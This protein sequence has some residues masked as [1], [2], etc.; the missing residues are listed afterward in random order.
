MK[1][2][3]PS[4][5]GA[6]ISAHFGRSRLFMVF[7]FEQGR[8]RSCEIRING[9]AIQSALDEE[10]HGGR[11]AHDHGAFARLLGDCGAVLCGGIGHGA[12]QVLEHAGLKVLIVDPGL[13]PE[14]AARAFDEGVL[15]PGR[16]DGCGCP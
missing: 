4:M 13:A 9:Q 3:I 8:A 1:I 5:D 15:Q 2:A 14:E 7:D 16:S 10:R 6:S 12:R 11:F